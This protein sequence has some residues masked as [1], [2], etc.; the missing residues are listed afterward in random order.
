MGGKT[1]IRK[2]V[3]RLKSWQRGKIFASTYSAPAHKLALEEVAERN[4]LKNYFAT[5]TKGPGLWKWQHYFEIYDR[6]FSRFRGN[7]PV[8]V[9]IGIFSG[10]SLPMWQSYFGEG[11][12]IIGID[13]EPA[14]KA[15][16]KD[17]VRVF[18]GDQADRD[19]WRRFREQIPHVDILIDDGGHE[20]EQQSVTLEEMLPHMAPG[21]VFLC[22]DI[23]GRH[24][25]FWRM[26]LSMSDEMNSTDL[27]SFMEDP[28]GWAERRNQPMGPFQK[29]VKSNSLHPFVAVIEKHGSEQT[30]LVSA[31]NGTEWQPFYQGK[32]RPKT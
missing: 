23:H 11:A 31:K 17:G 22:E 29:A 15:Y 21:G 20:P 12:Q 5:N 27:P 25:A 28:Q 1:Y 30:G 19:F 9:E 3:G 2:T 10:G 16:E 18:I 6:H 14:C 7:A 26:V 8:I 24:N 13:I 4:D 32:L